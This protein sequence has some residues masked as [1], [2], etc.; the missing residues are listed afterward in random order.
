MRFWLRADDSSAGMVVR[1][2]YPS[3]EARKV[4]KN[5][6]TIDMNQWDEKERQYGPVRNKFCGENR[7]IGVKNILEFY[8]TA[9]CEL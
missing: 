4:V 7:F 1:I 9:G 3:A 2:A 6:V 8:I 5:G